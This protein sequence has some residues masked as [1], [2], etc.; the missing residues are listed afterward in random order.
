MATSATDLATAEG[1]KQVIDN[2]AAR[3]E[4]VIFA[5]ISTQTDINAGWYGQL[6]D[7]EKIVITIRGVFDVAWKIAT[8]EV[9]A[10]NRASVTS[11][12]ATATVIEEAGGFRVNVTNLSGTKMVL[13]IVGIR[14]GGGSAL[15]D[16]LAALGVVA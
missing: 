13:R 2:L 14:S 10:T 6:S 1:V 15:A 12:G 5:G 16:L 7:F 9:A 4:A 3:E 11:Y 8:I